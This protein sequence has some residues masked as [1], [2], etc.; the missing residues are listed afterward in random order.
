MAIPIDPAGEV[1]PK[2]NT[3]FSTGEDM[4]RFMGAVAFAA[5]VL[6]LWVGAERRAVADLS[7]TLQSPTIAYVPAT[8][9]TTGQILGDIT[10]SDLR[11]PDAS[12]DPL[13]IPPQEAFPPGNYLYITFTPTTQLDSI[14]Q[15]G[16][17]LTNNQPLFNFSIPQGAALGQY[18]GGL[19]QLTG[20]EYGY[21]LPQQVFASYDMTLV[22]TSV[23]EPSTIWVAAGGIIAGIAYGCSRRRRKQ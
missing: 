17:T 2:R 8:G 13:V 3:V 9:S 22:A 19:M 10:V 20:I 12:L 18:T 23:P 11:I 6:G 15:T 1:D 21:L 7:L 5:T 14:L 4:N 16:G